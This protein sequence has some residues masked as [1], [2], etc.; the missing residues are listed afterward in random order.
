MAKVTNTP[1][2]LRREAGM[3]PAMPLPP[4]MSTPT[5]TPTPMTALAAVNQAPRIK[6]TATRVYGKAPTLGNLQ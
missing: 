1:I 3:K 5:P 2:S 4:S 6:P